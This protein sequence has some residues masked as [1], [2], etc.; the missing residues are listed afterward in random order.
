MDNIRD[1]IVQIL[2]ALEEV[3]GVEVEASKGRRSEERRVG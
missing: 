1:E 3:D 2:E